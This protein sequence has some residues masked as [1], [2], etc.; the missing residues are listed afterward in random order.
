MQLNI[1]KKARL[2]W[3]LT[4]VSLMLAAI[5][6]G[7]ITQTALAV[8]ATLVVDDD[9]HATAN[10]CNSGAVTPHTTVGSAIVA[11][12]VGDTVKVCPGTYSENV[13]IDKELNLRGAEADSSVKH[14]TFSDADESTISGLVTIQAP[15]VK[16]TGFSLTN[17]G[18]GLGAIVKTNGSGA[19]I[20]RNIVQT[21]GSATFGSPA[22]GVYLERGPD[23]VKVSGNKLSDIQSQSGSAQGILVGDSTSADPSLNTQINNNVISD[24]TS[25]TRGGYGIQLNNGAS[26]VAT[27]TGYTEASINGNT[28][29]NLSG[30]WAHGIGLEGETPN[31]L[32]EENTIQNLT[33]TTPAPVSDVIGVFF[34]DNP[35]FF[36]AQVNQNSLDVVPGN[37]GIAIHPDL[38]TQYPSLSVDGECNWWGSRRGPGTVGTGNGSMVS[39]GVDFKPW[40]HSSDLGRK[41]GDKNNHDG[42]HHHGD[43]GWNWHGHD[44]WRR[45]W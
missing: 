9:G 29:K 11:A 40:L 34:E 32:I 27:A 3:V 28:I 23:N 39:S 38:T 8:N 5:M 36:T 26:T 1:A 10:N 33:D 2:K 17:P 14:R 18:Q 12:S 13:V 41:C 25:I 35:F 19:V 31:A 6:T 22:V 42:D 4:A 30:N 7:T 43:W 37:Y 16:L 21:V 45:D 44:D 24:I 20:K 15:N